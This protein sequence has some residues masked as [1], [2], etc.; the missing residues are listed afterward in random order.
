MSADPKIIRD[1][2]K[3]AGAAEWSAA[4]NPIVIGKD[5]LELLSSSMYVDPMSIYR[6]YV[7]NAADAIDQRATQVQGRS[8]G[9]I[10]IR[11]DPTERR[12]VIRDNGTGLRAA[13][14][15]TRLINLGASTKRGTSARG[16]RGVGRLAGLGYCQEL[17]F[18][19]QFEGELTTSEEIGRAHV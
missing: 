5:V 3:A 11:I 9:H 1:R 14:F 4:K 16:F 19:S 13:E 12:I 2:A 8:P 15:A 6:E 7:Q 17:V 18:R 10:Q